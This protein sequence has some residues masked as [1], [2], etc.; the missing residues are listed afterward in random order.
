MSDV[1]DALRV[2]ELIEEA[3]AFCDEKAEEIRAL[4]ND[5]VRSGTFLMDGEDVARDLEK[6]ASALRDTTLDETSYV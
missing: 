1:G 2:N 4:V 5:E 3:A 6:A